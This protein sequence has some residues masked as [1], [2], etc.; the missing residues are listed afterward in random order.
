MT[1]PS[2]ARTGGQW[3]DDAVGVR[4][5]LSSGDISARELLEVEK[6]RGEKPYRMLEIGGAR[7]GDTLFWGAPGEL[8][9][10][11]ALETAVASPFRR[12]CC[13]GLANGYNGYI[14]T[15]GAFAGGGYEIRTARSSFLE[16]DAGSR[17]VA[18][19]K[20]LAER[21]RPAAGKDVA[22]LAARC[23]W[24]HFEDEEVLDGIRQITEGE[25]GETAAG[26]AGSG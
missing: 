4:S 11:F 18:A 7:I 12:T 25:S 1:L 19:A 22:G 17:V 26:S 23:V 16:P 3:L 13:V 6:M 5:R 2:S 21:M 15:P 9:Q 10:A 20:K 14:C 24:P 8:F